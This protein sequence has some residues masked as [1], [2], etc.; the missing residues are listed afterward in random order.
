MITREV[1]ASLEMIDPKKILTTARK[2][3]GV[4][5][6]RSEGE[7]FTLD[8]SGTAN[9]AKR[10]RACPPSAFKWRTTKFSP[11][12]FKRRRGPGRCPGEHFGKKVSLGK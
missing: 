7:A 3:S 10:G 2:W 11:A 5:G 4:K 1:N 12:F 8:A 6:E 9:A